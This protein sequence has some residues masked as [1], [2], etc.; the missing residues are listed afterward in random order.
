MMQKPGNYPISKKNLRAVFVGGL[1][2]AG[3][4]M[5]C[6][7]DIRGTGVLVLLSESWHSSL[8]GG[9]YWAKAL[10]DNVGAS[11]VDVVDH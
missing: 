3:S 10:P 2:Y 9:R 7:G 5:V 6:V 8:N 1:G 11:D 4:G